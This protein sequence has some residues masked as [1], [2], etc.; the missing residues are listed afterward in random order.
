MMK[1]LH[2]LFLG[3]FFLATN[4]AFTQTPYTSAQ[5]AYDSTLNVVYGTAVDYAGNTQS[6]TLDI[7]KPKGDQNCNRPIAVVI[8]GGAWIAGSKSDPYPTLLSRELVKRGYVVANINYRLGTH[9]T[10]NY[11][12]YALCNTSISAP[13]GYICDS[14]EVY[15]ANFRAMQ[16][17]KGA[18]RYMKSRYQTDSTDINNVYLV[19][20]S[21]GAFIALAAAYT[22]QTTEKHASCF[23][24]NNAPNPDPDMNTYGCIP[25]SNNL[26][27]PDLGSIDGTLHTGVYD[28]KV[29]AVASIY[30]GIMDLSILNQVNDTPAIYMYHQGS[31][32]VVNYNYGALLGRI[33]WECYA[34]TNLCQSYFFYPRAYGGEGLRQHFVSLG[35]NTPVYQA[36]IVNNYQYLNDCTDNGHSIDNFPLRTQNITNFFA[37][38]IAATGNTPSS[39]C[40][41]S[42]PNIEKAAIL[43]Y[44]NPTQQSFTIQSVTSIDLLN[45]YDIH[46]RRVFNATTLNSTSTINISQL[47]P[48][49]YIVECVTTSGIS[50]TRLIKN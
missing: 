17:A 40:A 9:K 13:C 5:F 7:Y 32:V 31:D 24:I 42:I 14:A 45:I 4:F 38:Q 20:E 37:T 10:S 25:T 23:A 41:S 15:R 6:L 8:H 48:G 28:S 3:L 12:M 26:S 33:S 29:N 19:G 2:A 1:Y 27:R 18:T 49:C 47:E 21:A 16:D 44:P 50:R 39:V 22:D 46:G 30:G 34:Q 43:L 36:D 35:N 11:T